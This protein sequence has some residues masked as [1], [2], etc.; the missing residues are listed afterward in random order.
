[1]K[2]FLPV[3]A[4]L[5]VAATATVSF[6][7]DRVWRTTTSL[8]GESRYADGFTHYD[9]VNPDAPKGG[10]LNVAATGTFDSFNPFIVQGTVANGIN[11]QGGLLW[12]L[13]MDKALDEPSASH[14]MIAEA[15]TYPDDYSQATYRLNP[16]ARWHDGTPITVEDVK[17]S[18]ETLKEHSPQYNK[19]FGDVQEVRIDNE[20]EVTF[21]FAQKN[22]RELPLIMGD[23]PVLPKHWWEGTGP[24]GKKRD[25]TRSTLEPPL[26]SGPY[27]VGSFQ[28]GSS[29]IFERVK[30]YW[31]ADMPTAKGRFNF[32]RIRFTYFK[33][34]NAL[35]EAFKKGGFEDIRLENRAQRWSTEYTFPAFKQGLVKKEEFKEVSGH[36]MTGFF[37][38]ARRPQ[39]SD[40]KVREA[41]TLAMNFERMNADLFFGKYTRTRSYFGGT[42]L[43]PKGKPQGRELEILEAYRGKIDERIFEEPFQLPVYAER[44]DERRFLRKALS[45]LKEAGW[46]QRGTELVNAETGEPFKIEILGFDPS[47]DRVNAPW[48]RSL[49]RLGIDV[50]FRV[51]DTSQYIQRLNNFDYD[52]IFHGVQQSQSPGNEQREY[53]SSAAAKEP[54]S[55]NYSGISDPVIDELIEKLILAKDRAELVAMTHALDRLLVHGF[56]VVPGWYLDADWVAYWDKFGIPRP[57]PP[58]QGHDP[59]SWW[60]DPE[61]EAAL[62]A[63]Q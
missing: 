62:E 41:L 42:E 57:Q 22:N 24:D 23:L 36:A 12:D 27:K 8:I 37:L 19:Y 38:N 46:E 17:W 32:D 25:F 20:R 11:Y 59:Y 14:P 51:V 16:D 49:E 40:P 9:H 30:D 33:D 7:D 13:L 26:G 43:E 35:W 1:M 10:T 44:A 3:L 6:A 60:I 4:S 47:R 34:P 15:F 50:S 48:S 28:A 2:R 58:Y 45:L 54:G 55:R 52:V 18:M 21:I 63:A 29:V 56:Y 31:A 53:W 39:L 61:K 5:L